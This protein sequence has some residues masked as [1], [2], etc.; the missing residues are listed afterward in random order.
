LKKRKSWKG[1]P[2]K[3]DKTKT[4]YYAP[5][6]DASEEENNNWSNLVNSLLNR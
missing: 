2:Y 4:T 6:E 1:T 3:S 5:G